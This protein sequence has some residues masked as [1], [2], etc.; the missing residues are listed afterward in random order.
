MC[1]TARGASVRGAGR[2]FIFQVAR[3]NA[4]SAIDDLEYRLNQLKEEKL[5]VSTEAPAGPGLAGGAA[6]PV[7]EALGGQEGAEGRAERGAAKGARGSGRASTSWS[8]PLPRSVNWGRRRVAEWEQ[9]QTD[10]LYD[11]PGRQRL[12]N[13]SPERAGARRHG[14]QGAEGQAEGARGPTRQA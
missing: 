3:N 6:G 9:F 1:A 14:E 2:G 13:R 11:R 12:Q 7:P 10:L 8:A 5:S 4:K